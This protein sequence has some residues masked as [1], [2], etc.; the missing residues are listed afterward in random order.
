MAERNGVLKTGSRVR[1]GLASDE[2]L[3]A[4][5]RRGDTDAFEA[6]YDR[7]VRELLGFCLYMLSSRQDAEDA[8]QATFASAYRALRADSRPVAL[9]PWLFTI[10]RNDCLSILRRR[11]PTVELNGEIAPGA[12]PVDQIETREEVRKVFEGLRE[13]PESQRAALVL[14]EVHGLSHNEVGRVLGVRSEQVKAFVYQARSK[15]VSERA[16][17][18]VDCREIR[19]ELSSARGAALLRGRL[20][21]HVRSCPECRTFAAGVA[22]QRRALGALLPVVPSLALKYRALEGA[23]RIPSSDPVTVAG[24]ATVGATAAG[25][26]AELAGGGLNA[27]VCKVAVGVACLGASAGVGVSVLGS[28]APSAGQ[29]G[30]ATTATAPLLASVSPA[31][32]SPWTRTTVA[33]EEGGGNSTG[34][35]LAG[36]SAGEAPSEGQAGPLELRNGAAAD[37]GAAAGGGYSREGSTR[38]GRELRSGQTSRS[39]EG[40]SSSDYE[41]RAAAEQRQIKREGHRKLSEQN[42]LAREEPKPKGGSRPP[43]SEEELLRKHEENVR[44]RS[45]QKPEGH[46]RPPKTQEEM[47]LKHE[48][49]E[50]LRAEKRKLREEAEA[51]ARLAEEEAA[52]SGP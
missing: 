14:A 44:R 20:R 36:G 51:R 13:L 28:P 31:D 41:Q 27:I 25:T 52:A 30:A 39:G 16:A 23:L 19:E 38:A 47:R 12:D 22:R 9:R 17:R 2:W 11:R 34:E 35:G 29:P 10:A 37:E 4:C 46:S 21:R 45:E 40:E 33:L 50:R 7:H 24:G 1:L 48:R 43:K 15:L 26:A 18:D 6:L 49:S 42:R 5:V 3:V 32:A 8:V